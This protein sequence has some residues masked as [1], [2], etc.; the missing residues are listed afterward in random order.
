MN[1]AIKSS[2]HSKYL[3][4][5][6]ELCYDMSSLIKLILIVVVFSFFPD[7]VKFTRLAKEYERHDSELNK[8]NNELRRLTIPHMDIVRAPNSGIKP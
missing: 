8:L 6:L 7:L 3:I 4:Q 2:H 1:F 5:H